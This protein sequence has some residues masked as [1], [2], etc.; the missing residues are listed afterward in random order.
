MDI[1]VVS[2]KVF[3]EWVDTPGTVIYEAASEGQVLYEAS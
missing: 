3:H 2:D 1:I